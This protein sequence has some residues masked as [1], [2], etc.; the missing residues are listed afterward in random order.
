[1]ETGNCQIRLKIVVLTGLI[2]GQALECS[3]CVKAQ[4]TSRLKSDS[5]QT[6]KPRTSKLTDDDPRAV[7]THDEWDRV[8]NAVRRALDW[9]A[10]QQLEDGSFPTLDTGQPAVTSL[11]TL[12]FMANGHVPRDVGPY[13]QRLERAVGYVLNC[14][15]ESGLFALSA[16]EGET[17]NR[18]VSQEVGVTTAYNHAISALA[19]SEIYGMGFA[20]ES[21]QPK[22]AITDSLAA[23]LQ[24]QGWP[25]NQAEDKGGWRYVNKFDHWDSDVSLTGW[26]LMFLRSARN[27]GFDVPKQPIDD[28]VA[29][30]R[31]AFSKKYGTFTYI[32][33][34]LDTRSRA[35]AGA[36]IL[37][38]AHAGLHN[39][40]EAQQAGEWLLQ[41]KFDKY[42]R[43]EPFTTTVW[44]HD[45]YHYAVF[46]ACQGTYQ[47]GGRYWK[48]FF[49]RIV[50]TLLKNQ[51]ADGS[52][53]AES[54]SNDGR[55]GN[56]YTTALM[57]LSLGAPNQLLPIFQR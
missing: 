13:G 54:H 33:S 19:I 46:Y 18:N 55:Y 39:T 8:D 34:P 37:A 24:M 42:N 41:Q 44:Q 52:W 50:P 51:N 17:I 56:A 53:A 29:Y 15:K 16:P 38:M 7:L 57:V 40:P 21:K 32:I 9:L 3:P 20:D 6:G 26:E 31:R 48:E 43:V 49:P 12:A 30:I 27:A 22:Q 2:V 47:L 5:K 1:M 14:Q 36:G 11:C 28:A 25:K 35:M 45:R 4:A 10:H 23:T